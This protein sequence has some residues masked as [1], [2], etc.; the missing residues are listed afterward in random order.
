[1]L[2]MLEDMDFSGYGSCLVDLGWGK[3][4]IQLLG[5]WSFRGV[6]GLWGVARRYYC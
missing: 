4:V 5:I 1:M 2:F 3:T 6:F